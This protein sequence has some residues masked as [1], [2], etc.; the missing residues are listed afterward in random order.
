M[1]RRYPL[2]PFV[3]ERFAGF[4]GESVD[5]LKADLL[6]GGAC[7]SNY[8][9]S[10]PAG[11]RWVCR[12]YCRGNPGAEAR[13]MGMVSGLVPVPEIVWAGEEGDVAVMRYLEG[14]MFSPTPS[15]MRE[16]GQLIG[17]LSQIAF[18]EA[19][20][21]L[22]DGTTRP[23]E[24][25]PSFREGLNALLESAAVRGYLERSVIEKL[26]ELLSRRSDW[27][28]EFDQ[29]CNLVHGD[30]KSCNLLV[31]GDRITGLL[32]WEFAHSG[33]S[34]M[35]MGNLLRDL[36]SRWETDLEWGLREEGFELAED[37]RARARLID[38]ASHLEFL[39]SQRADAFKQRCVGRVLE[40]IE[41][42]A[43][44]GLA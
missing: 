30:F 44:I 13:V 23:F 26:H 5:G 11:E 4:F 7:N 34:Y 28:H 42:E 2:Q 16:A 21:L 35:D 24:G 31:S 1:D 10:T 6:H 40:L 19:G 8:L 27:L 32:D 25:W 33:C 39:S 41:S 18:G 43:I 38:L 15:R 22:A 12:I 36:D 9:V 29:C 37:W 17:R 20:Q 3:P 14:E